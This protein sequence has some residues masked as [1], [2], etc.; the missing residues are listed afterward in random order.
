M[1]GPPEGRVFIGFDGGR[2]AAEAVL[3]R[4]D[5]APLR[6]AVQLVE[7]S[8]EASRRVLQQQLPRL[9]RPTG[10]GNTSGTHETAAAA[11]SDGDLT[12][13]YYALCRENALAAAVRTG[14]AAALMFACT[15]RGA[16]FYGET[17]VE[18]RL[19]DG[20]F[21]RE[22]PFAGMFAGG[23]IGP[24]VAGG[25]L[26]RTSCPPGSSSGDND[27]V[28]ASP[29]GTASELQGYTSMIAVISASSL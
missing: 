6:L 14:P 2:A 13:S 3:G 12:A 15:G 26:G 4:G 29:M 25:M 11:Q 17:G 10:K 18:A 24:P 8:H 5:P 20:I 23:E 28:G 16:A 19:V 7:N 27:S 9:R 1:G 22:V 21:N